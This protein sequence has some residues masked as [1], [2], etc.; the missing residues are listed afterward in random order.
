MRSLPR[1]LILVAAMIMTMALGSCTLYRRAVDDVP[2][3]VSFSHT[4][5]F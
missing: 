1:R 5:G 3:R 4:W 2:R